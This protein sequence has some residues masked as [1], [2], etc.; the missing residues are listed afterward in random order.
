MGQDIIIRTHVHVHLILLIV[1]LIFSSCE[2][3]NLPGEHQHNMARGLAT[4]LKTA[5]EHSSLTTNVE[6]VL[7]SAQ[8]SEILPHRYP[9][10]LVDVVTYHNTGISMVGAK[11]VTLNEPHFTGHFLDLPMMP[12]V[13]QLEAL[14][15]LARIFLLL[16]PE[17][18]LSPT[19][20]LYNPKGVTWEQPELV[21][22]GVTLWM[23]V[24]LKNR[25]RKPVLTGNAWVNGVRVLHVDELKFFGTSDD[26]M[27]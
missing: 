24:K 3:Q 12:E 21:V 15:Q 13:L 17:G 14:S 9:F 7:N 27:S 20:A 5:Q 25:R 26:L 1:L 2:V 6:T 4:E 19:L 10:L 11:A 16:I 18:E 8:I 23:E 22:P